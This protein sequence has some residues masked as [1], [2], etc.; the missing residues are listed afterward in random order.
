MHRLDYAVVDVCLSV[1]LSITR[2]Y[3]VL[4][5]IHILKVFSQSG[6]PNILVFPRQTRWQYSD[7]DP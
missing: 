4:T 3:C 2:L 6:S 7:G 5:V 1:C